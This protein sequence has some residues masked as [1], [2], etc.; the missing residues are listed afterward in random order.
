M[1]G[2]HGQC[3][4]DVEGER[5]QPRMQIAHH[6]AVVKSRVCY[7]VMQQFSSLSTYGLGNNDTETFR[8]V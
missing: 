8:A 6:A 3:R 5:G 7:E 4:M 1:L 2:G